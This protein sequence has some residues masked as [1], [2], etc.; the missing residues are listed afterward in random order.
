MRVSVYL[1]LALVLQLLVLLTELGLC[2][3]RHHQ[4]LLLLFDARAGVSCLHPVFEL[5]ELLSDH[6]QMVGC[7]LRIVVV[8]V[9]VVA[10]LKWVLIELVL[11]TEE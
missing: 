4:G 9:S 3:G 2:Q 1:I 5:V 8:F 7:P 10:H 11:L 6:V